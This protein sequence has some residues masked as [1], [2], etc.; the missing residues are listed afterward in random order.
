MKPSRQRKRKAL[1]PSLF[2]AKINEATNT[3]SHG[4]S[5]NGGTKRHEII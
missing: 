4:E 2:N 5:I 1:K 3:I